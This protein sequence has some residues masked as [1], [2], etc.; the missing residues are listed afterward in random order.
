MPLPLMQLHPPVGQRLA[1][2]E[3]RMIEAYR[4]EIIDLAALK[5]EL[6]S[7]KERGA[8]LEGERE[9]MR[10]QRDAGRIE[11]ARKETLEDRRKLAREGAV[12]LDYAGRR[13]VLSQLEIA[14]Y[15]ESNTVTISGM[16]WHN[17]CLVFGEDGTGAETTLRRW[18]SPP[19]EQAS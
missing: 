11:A 5:R 16:L 19:A 7:I 14:C 10:R 6:T 9:E 12:A 15:V 4:Q 8:V 18:H 1:R 2:E 13:R 17:I 3:S